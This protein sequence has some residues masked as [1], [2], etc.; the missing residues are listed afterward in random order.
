M[1]RKRS[2]KTRLRIPLPSKPRPYRPGDG[3]PLAPL[4]IVPENDL[5]AFI[6]DK[7]VLRT[8]A[9]NGELKLQMFYVVGWP[10]LP[11]ARVAILATDV[12]D[13][14]SQ[15]TVE[16]FEYKASLEREEEE[17]RKEAEKRRR[18]QVAAA[19][20]KA[21]SAVNA[22]STPAV[23]GAPTVP[24]Q[25][26][27]G[28]PSKAILEARQLALQAILDNATDTEEPLPA[29]TSGPSLSTPK[30]K[31]TVEL[32]TNMDEAEAEAD[33]D[34][35]IYRQLCGE[36]SEPDDMIV[37]NDEG[38]ELLQGNIPDTISS[39]AK[40]TAH[41]QKL[42][43]KKGSTPSKRSD[44]RLALKSPNTHVPVPNVPKPEK[45][46]SPKQPPFKPLDGS[47]SMT[48]VPVPLPYQLSSQP[49]PSNQPASTQSYG[50]V[51]PLR[52]PRA[53]SYTPQPK[54]FDGKHSTTP[55]PVPSWPHSTAETRSEPSSS[56]PPEP[57]KTLLPHY[58]FTPAG[59]SPGRWP[60]TSSSQP[61]GSTTPLGSAK[62]TQDSKPSDH[63]G[64]D[65]EVSSSRKKKK[66]KQQQA[67]EDQQQL[68]VVD[69]LE[70]ERTV[71]TEDGERARYFKV[72]WEGEWPPD[73]NPTWEPEENIAPHLVRRYLK[74]KRKSG[75]RSDDGDSPGQAVLPPRPLLKRKYSSVMEAFEGD[76]DDDGTM[77]MRHG[78]HT[79]PADDGEESDGQEEV[80]VVAAEEPRGKNTPRHQPE[81]L[82]AKFLRD[83][84]AA[85]NSTHDQEARS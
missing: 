43:R 48:P 49:S 66:P 77:N 44:G 28:R 20:K 17:K 62:S 45:Q 2:K 58:G 32:A 74:R 72:R 7:R 31:R 84:T 1:D 36:E 27:R 69:R 25:K 80:L 53:V 57:R 59:R 68:W 50:G 5:N 54:S 21:K 85:I 37:D 14:V 29:S 16:D 23:P 56:A 81:E 38:D 8:T 26:K 71:L 83:L 22:T 40:I 34:N 46:S 12:Y 65:G 41:A 3:P 30:K 73:Q 51:A 47:K 55:I 13:Y 9:A 11:A 33:A 4:T 24:G 79:D 70:G 67:P 39:P 61:T 78:R 15:K 64:D 76:G 10:D 60:S 63:H 19:A 35:A 18:A 82:E 52:P 75:R 6:A 42:W